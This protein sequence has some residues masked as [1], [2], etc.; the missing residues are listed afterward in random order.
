M[1]CVSQYLGEGRQNYFGG[2]LFPFTF[3]CNVS[4]VVIVMVSVR[5]RIQDNSKQ[6]AFLEYLETAFERGLL[7]RA[8]PDNQQDSIG[9]PRP[10]R[11]VSQWQQWWGVDDH[12]I[13][14]GCELLD[15]LRKPS[16]LH[17][18]ERMSLVHLRRA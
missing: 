18:F 11:R 12:P 4:L 17:Q 10:H 13:K 2:L 1:T 9:K 7:R 8:F 3:L 16:R 14:Q 5:G 6:V 15:Q